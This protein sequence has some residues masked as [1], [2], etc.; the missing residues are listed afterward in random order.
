[1]IERLQQLLAIIQAGTTVIDTGKQVRNLPFLI[2]QIAS[3]GLEDGQR[4]GQES[5]A[6]LSGLFAVTGNHHVRRE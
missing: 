6:R 5:C 3:S 2:R 4:F 1:M